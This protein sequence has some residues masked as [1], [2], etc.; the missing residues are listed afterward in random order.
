MSA[1]ASQIDYWNSDATRWWSERHESIDRM[2]G[3]ITEQVLEM[4]A[5]QTGER[6]LD[7]GCATGT[8]VLAIAERVGADGHVLGIDIAER[9]VA[10]AKDRIAAAGVGN[11]EA[12]VADASVHDFP[13]RAFDLMFSRFG[14]MFFVDPAA[15]FAHLHRSLASDG[16]FAAMAFRSRQENVWA[17]GPAAA[18]RDILPAEPPPDPE[19]PGQFAWA[20]EERVRRILGNAG[21]RDVTLTKLDPV[22]R[23]AEP[24][25]A[26]GA[27]E[28]LLTIGPVARIAREMPP[29]RRSALLPR[30]EAYFREKEGPDG[31][32]LP[33]AI[34]LVRARP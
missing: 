26:A 24:G 22:F 4:I 14:V 3:A 18:L 19:A 29:E 9:S 20:S 11:A 30:L 5:P 12:I 15:T 34:W 31:I 1:N 21:F 7:I 2:L 25:D 8:T 33:G 28:R 16:R 6:V 23:L 13:P 17:A 10:R 32:A 27:A